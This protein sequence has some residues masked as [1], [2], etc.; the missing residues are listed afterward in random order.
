M[1][2]LN[3]SKMWNNYEILHEIGRGGMG[4]VYKAQ[5]K[6]PSRMVAIKF[7]QACSQV[8]NERFLREMKIAA[9]LDHLNIPKVYDAG[10]E[11]DYKYLVMD[12]I[13]G[14]PIDHY[15]QKNRLSV[16]KKIA[17]F[18][19]VCLAVDYA[20]SN[21]I[22]HRDLKPNN[23]LVN[24]EGKPFVIDFG[25]AKHIE[26]EE[27]DLTKSGE[28]LGTPNYMA[29]EQI[30]GKR[31]AIDEQAD[32]YAL[33]TL[34]YKILTGRNMVEGNHFFEI[35]CKIQDSDFIPLLKA[36]PQLN[37]NLGI[38]W[39]RATH[40]KKCYRYPSIQKLIND[41]DSFSKGKSIKKYYFA[42]QILYTVFCCTIFLF[43]GYHIQPQVSDEI[44][45]SQK[46][47]K[48]QKLFEQL[49]ADIKNRSTKNI[50][51]T[52]LTVLTTV[53]QLQ[54]AKKLYQHQYYQ[55][56]LQV[57]NSLPET[58]EKSYYQGLIFYHQNQYSKAQ[59]KLER[60]V[61]SD[62]SN[63]KVN[64]YL[65]MCYLQQQNL[66]KALKHLLLAEKSFSDIQLLETIAKIY[67]RYP[68]RNTKKAEEYFTRCMNEAPLIAKYSTALGKINLENK[69]YYQAFVYL[70]QALRLEDKFEAITLIH[71]IPYY[72]PELKRMCYH[73]LIHE[74]LIERQIECPDLF[75]DMWKLIE[76]RYRDD[77]I[78]WKEGVKKINSSIVSF[79]IPIKNDLSIAQTVKRA[80]FSLR[81]SK[82]FDIDMANF[83]Q[84]SSLSFKEKAFF[85]EIQK[86]VRQIRKREQRSRIYYLLTHMYRNN[87]WQEKRFL[88]I[89]DLELLDILREERN[90]ILKYLVAKGYLNTFG[91]KPMIRIVT[92]NKEKV[93]TRI[94]CCA[95]LRESFLASRIDIFQELPNIK[96]YSG[97]QLEFLQTLVARTIYV[98]HNAR[99][100]DIFYR[101]RKANKI[102]PEEKKLLYYLLKQKSQKVSISAASSLHAL[103]GDA[104]FKNTQKMRT[105]IFQAMKSSDSLISSYAYYM[106]WGNLTIGKNDEYF[107]MYKKALQ[108]TNH[109]IR[110]IT[111]SY[112]MVFRKKIPELE[113]EIKNCLVSP[114][115]R[116]RLSAIFLWS[117]SPESNI[118]FDDP[119]FKERKEFFSDI[120]ISYSIILFFSKILREM[121]ADQ[122]KILNMI[123]FL[124]RLKIE[125]YTLPSISQCMIAY[126][127]AISNNHPSTKQLEKIKDP[128]LLSYLLF[129]LHQGIYSDS[130]QSVFFL[131][132]RSSKQKKYTARHFLQHKN[133]KIRLSATTSFVA[134]ASKEQK[135]KY[136]NQARLSENNS[137]KKAVAQ[138]LY[139]AL[140]NAWIKGSKRSKSL[141]MLDFIS[142]HSIEFLLNK[143]LSNIKSFISRTKQQSP[144]KYIQYKKW[145]EHA[146]ELSPSND[147]L[148]FI[149]A[150]FSSDDESIKNIKKAIYLNKK[151]RAGHVEDIYYLWLFESL[152][153]KS[154]YADVEI[155]LAKK[156]QISLFLLSDIAQ[157]YYRLNNFP[158]ALKTYEK[159]F[160]TKSTEYSPF[161]QT[162]S[163]HLFMVQIY[164]KQGDIEEAK[165]LLEYLYQ[166][167]RRD[168]EKFKDVTKE[169]FLQKVRTW[170]PEIDIN[171]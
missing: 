80:L 101:Q 48:Q 133:E 57:L 127:L 14:I 159:N 152:I 62:Q 124:Q 37:R 30:T 44:Q 53:Q 12:Y 5:Q 130:Q 47:I 135:Q 4:V 134:F 131:K 63:T 149:R 122:S 24:E 110:K 10:V 103:L 26:K 29:P 74:S 123:S 105:V 118:I 35:I 128:Q 94:I 115:P 32:I 147:Q 56:A 141:N 163:D 153:K 39:K 91:F 36:K 167:D 54:I 90:P 25:L 28:L 97:E 116:V 104:E 170:H 79:L 143:D 78:E 98:R 66:E 119:L 86:D 41:L 85:L 96:K 23:I 109:Q 16:K 144:E 169:H 51:I 43:I 161:R 148:W 137:L 64:Y 8:S 89:K 46:D 165:T 158:L 67:L 61:L 136:Y 84:N 60:L 7:S 21:K 75:R 106:F 99:V 77:S 142:H 138:G 154:R 132:T 156:K 171:W 72:A 121:R 1:S 151:F 139:F 55:E 117:L 22:V 145:I 17:L 129:H 162:F 155:H 20:H 125:I 168:Q 114:L 13:S 45:L 150:F 88:K 2:G 76:D 81:Y 3:F 38:I 9:N 49:I 108:H 126:L 113:Q 107:A 15:V 73:A 50:Q 70:K 157:I 33:G 92:N 140:Q 42:P 71:K 58:I 18:Y 112:A 11:H 102:D 52:T 40:F 100:K 160:L 34:F 19:D 65:G 83:L 59:K 93:M 164:I 6:S 95:V 120:E 27:F 69:K 68:C 146:V 87:S 166:L 82:T 111:L 31:S